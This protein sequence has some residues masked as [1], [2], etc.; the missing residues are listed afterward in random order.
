MKKQAVEKCLTVISMSSSLRISAL[1]THANSEADAISTFIM[2]YQ[3]FTTNLNGVRRRMALATRE[4]YTFPK[5]AHERYLREVEKKAR[6][7]ARRII[8]ASRR[9]NI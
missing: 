3:F 2:F 4:R 6:S 9:L 1:Y 5:M 7:H 8:S